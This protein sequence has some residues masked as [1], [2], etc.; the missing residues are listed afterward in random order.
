MVLVAKALS[1]GYVPVG[2]V[3]ATPEV[4]RAVFDEMERAVVHG[5][6]F[7]GNDLAAAA[8][9]AVRTVI[10]GRHATTATAHASANRTLLDDDLIGFLC[11]GG[12][13]SLR[14][15]EGD[16]GKRRG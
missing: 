14:P 5:S 12:T 15:I 6:T 10:E 7:G 11:K 13:R 8:G 1:G 4:F 16:A 3:L 9:L 2:A